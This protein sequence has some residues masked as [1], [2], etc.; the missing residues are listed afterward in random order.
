MA[1]E[2]FNQI[3]NLGLKG[4]LEWVVTLSR[5]EEEIKELRDRHRVKN[6]RQKPEPVYRSR[7]TAS[8]RK[9]DKGWL[10]QS[11]GWAREEKAW[12]LF[13]IRGKQVNHFIYFNLPLP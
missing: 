2:K 3:R 4:R 6:G 10:R 7:A 5:K 11:E 8:T 1:A 9:K 13:E 12:L